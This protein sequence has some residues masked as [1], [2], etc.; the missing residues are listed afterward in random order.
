MIIMNLG[1]PVIF[2][3]KSGIYINLPI[4]FLSLGEL[5]PQVV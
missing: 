3:L 4:M 2:K 1:V 5:R